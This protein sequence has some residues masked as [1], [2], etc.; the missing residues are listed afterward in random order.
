MTRRARFFVLVG[1]LPAVPL[2]FPTA[3]GA[4][5][6]DGNYGFGSLSARHGSN[7]GGS[8]SFTVV[9][10][11]R[12]SLT[13]FPDGT[14]S[15]S[16]TEHNVCET[17]ASLTAADAGFG[18][19][20]ADGEGRVTLDGGTPDEAHLVLRPD[21]DAAFAS[22]DS[23][24]QGPLLSIAIRLSSGLDAAVLNGAYH[25]GRLGF[26]NDGTGTR[27]DV[28]NGT[29]TFDGAGAVD[30]DF[31]SKSVAADGTTT[32]QNPAFSGG[33]SVAPNGLLALGGMKGTVSSD[34]G[35][36]FLVDASGQ[37]VALFVGVPVA[38]A[39]GDDLFGGAWSRGTLAARFGAEVDLP[40]FCSELAELDVTTLTSSFTLT[41]VEVCESPSEGVVA[42]TVGLGTFSVSA[43]GALSIFNAGLP[44]AVGGAIDPTGTL[45]VVPDVV[46]NGSVSMALVVRTGALP[47]PYG[48]GKPGTGGVEPI[49]GSSGGF[50]Y[51]GNPD[52][53]FEITQALPD[54]PAF[55]AASLL[56]SPGLT[57]LG[58]TIWID[59]AT[60]VF[61][62]ALLTSG[63]GEATSPTPIPSD[64]ALNDLDL[65]AQALVVDPGAGAAGVAMT[66]GLTVPIRR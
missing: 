65:Y 11:E 6:L 48:T 35:V 46:V 23:A 16:A 8:S 20:A 54:A 32:V 45:A 59:P 28:W 13:F 43:D 5:A 25:F 62:K 33:Y 55:L 44:P 40:E 4:L 21:L 30:V 58:G 56:P 7:C 22:G 42:P 18:T 66:A 1:V 12:G 37:D 60:Q 36:F 2:A 34:G 38:T 14:Y 51:L 27:G 47:T 26:T 63:A 39:G 17:G 3:Q 53:A 29:M 24:E 31:L 61:A 19:Y 9:T 41:G 15:V 64:P 52:F 50:P 57:L 10:S 49:L